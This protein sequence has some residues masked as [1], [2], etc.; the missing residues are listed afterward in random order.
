MP[1]APAGF[2]VLL[3]DLACE[4]RAHGVGLDTENRPP[5]KQPGP[6]Q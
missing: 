6:R 4:P 5:M 2:G 1:H 3:A